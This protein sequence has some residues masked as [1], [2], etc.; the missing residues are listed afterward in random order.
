MEDI[1][2]WEV[3]KSEY[4]LERPWLTAR[5]D[6]VKLPDGRIND[7]YWVLEYPAWINVIASTPEGRYIMVRQYRHGLGIISTELCAGV[8]EQGEDPLV[9][10]RRELAEE[11]GYTD[12]TWSLNCI[13]SANPGSQN[14]LTY[15]FIAENVTLSATQHLDDTED[16]RIEL[17]T[18]EELAALLKGGTMRQALMLS[19]LWKYFAERYPDLVKP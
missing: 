18:R 16:L 13:V 4:Y 15:C 1:R 9:A 17:L 19:S 7:E 3:I 2:P 10:A 14:N 11:T 8:A 6:T 5:R 12:G